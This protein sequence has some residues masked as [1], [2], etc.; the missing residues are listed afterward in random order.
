VWAKQLTAKFQNFGDNRAAKRGKQ[1]HRAAANETAKKAGFSTLLLA[2]PSNGSTRD[3]P[4]RMKTCQRG[5]QEQSNQ[6]TILAGRSLAG[7]VI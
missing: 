7:G 3:V 2:S 6:S 1:R 5:L 4:R